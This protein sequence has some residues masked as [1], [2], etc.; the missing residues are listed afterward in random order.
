MTMFLMEVHSQENFPLVNLAQGTVKGKMVNSTV[1]APFYSFQGIPYAKPPVEQLRFKAPVAPDPWN[2]TFEAFQEGNI[3]RQ[4]NRAE[5]KV[6]GSE[7]CLYINVFTPQLPGSEPLKPVMVFIHGGAYKTGS[8]NTAGLTPDYLV[9]AGVVFVSFNYRLDVLGFLSTEDS[10]VPGNAAM[11]DQVQALCWIKQNIAA[12]GGDPNKVTI[13]GHSAGGSS[14]HYLVLSPMAKG[15]FRA[16]IAQSGSAI[17]PW[18]LAVRPRE[19]AFILGR[20]LGYSGNSSEELVGFLRTISCQRL[21]TT[22]Q[23]AIPDRDKL[24][25]LRMVFVPS[26]EPTVE[27]EMSFLPDTPINLLNQGTFQKVP[28]ISGVAN[29]E[30]IVF[31]RIANILNNFGR[32]QEINENFLKT[33]KPELRFCKEDLCGNEMVARMKSFYFGDQDF[34]NDTLENFI[35]LTSDLFFTEGVEYGVNLMASQSST[36]IYLYEFIYDGGLAM[37][38]IRD[39]AQNFSGET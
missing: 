2:G 30:G 18:A 4:F 38:K 33:L 29:G 13:F 1:T 9:G 21:L 14:V 5:N 24:R 27:G 39:G 8:G 36:P 31:L 26:V 37:F 3:C 6:Y 20:A 28:F 11:K 23:E 12:F 15:L 22:A 7:D 35:D 17:N 34:N 16:A 25:L 10:A 19:S 32:V